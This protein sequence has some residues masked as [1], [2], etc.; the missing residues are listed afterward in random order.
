MGF[1]LKLLFCHSNRPLIRL[2][3][4]FLFC[5]YIPSSLTLFCR[6]NDMIH[7]ALQKKKMKKK[8]RNEIPFSESQSLSPHFVQN[9]KVNT[10]KTKLNDIDGGIK[11]KIIRRKKFLKEL[12]IIICHT[13]IHRINIAD[14]IV[15][16]AA[17]VID[18]YSQ[19]NAI[20]SYWSLINK[21][22]VHVGDFYVSN[23]GKIVIYFSSLALLFWLLS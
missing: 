23:C 17:S 16:A 18:D 22:S 8:N 14:M 9:W 10:Q 21:K 13:A 11:K 19:F 3:S 2:L 4:I 7:V 12:I 15:A 5:F 1:R 20:Y 6:W